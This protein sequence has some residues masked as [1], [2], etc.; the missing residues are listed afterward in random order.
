MVDTGHSPYNNLSQR[1]IEATQK[2]YGD[3]LIFF[4]LDGEIPVVN[5]RIYRQETSL[6][7][8][9]DYCFFPTATIESRRDR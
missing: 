4:K 6:I 9:T 3:M 8:K 2:R 5:T 7:N 1:T